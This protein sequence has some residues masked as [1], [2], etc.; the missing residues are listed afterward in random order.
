M[1]S[2]VRFTLPGY[3]SFSRSLSVVDRGGL[4]IRGA[5]ED[6]DAF[7]TGEGDSGPELAAVSA[8]EVEDDRV[9]VNTPFELTGAV[10]GVLDR[11]TLTFALVILSNWMDQR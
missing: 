5:E 2:L 9:G 6:N 1:H 3:K 11:F 8:E 4:V 7:K 10:E